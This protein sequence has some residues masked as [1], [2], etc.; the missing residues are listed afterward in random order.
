MRQALL[1]SALPNSQAHLLHSTRE[2]FLALGADSGRYPS[3]ENLQAD[4][5]GSSR[6]RNRVGRQTGRAQRRQDEQRHI[7]DWHSSFFA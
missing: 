5:H 7:P 3:N 4:H 6:M 2:A 1:A